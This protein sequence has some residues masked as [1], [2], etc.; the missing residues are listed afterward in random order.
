MV[1]GFLTK[2]GVFMKKLSLFA[3]VFVF[4][5]CIST[6]AL[7][8]EVWASRNSNV[9]HFPNSGCQQGKHVNPDDI[10][11]FRT[12]EEAKAAG[13]SLCRI[14]AYRMYPRDTPPKVFPKD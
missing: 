14:C 5:C 13:Y 7:S 11:T 9:Y 2:R 6:L 1:A 3:G 12:V 10:V 4:I 8:A